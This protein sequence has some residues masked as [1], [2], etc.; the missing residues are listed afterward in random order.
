M[1]N[2]TVG[3]QC[4]RQ[5]SGESHRGFEGTAAHWPAWHRATVLRE[6]HELSP[7][8]TSVALLI[9]PTNANLAE[10][11]RKATEVAARALGLKLHILNATDE[12]GIPETFATALK[13]EARGLL[14]SVD[15]V[16]TREAANLGALTVHYKMPAI[17]FLREFVAAGGLMS[18]S[19]ST[20]EYHYV[21]GRYS[22]RILKGAKSGGPGGPT[23]NQD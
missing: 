12:R 20:V 3:R 19:G 8:A 16:F 14:I 7:A 15:A 22:G 18:Y 9:N 4:W 10:P 1:W 11:Q 2:G 6:L 21:A 5:M 13:L 23:S 17:H